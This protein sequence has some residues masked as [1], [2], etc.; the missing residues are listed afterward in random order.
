[1]DGQAVSPPA[2]VIGDSEGVT[3]VRIG[4]K[5]LAVA[6][7]LTVSGALVACGGG[8]GAAGGGAGSE[9][10]H[11]SGP[12]RQ[13]QLE[14]CAQKE[15]GMLLYTQLIVD[16]AVKPL[17]AGFNKQYPWAKVDYLRNSGTT[18]VQR[19][20]NEQQA[21]QVQADVYEGTLAGGAAKAAGVLQSF[22]T[23]VTDDYPQQ[24]LD[25]DHMWAPDVHYYGVFAYNTNE[26]PAA[27]VPKSYD[28]LLSPFWQNK[29]AFGSDPGN[30]GPAF[31]T[32]LR[33]AWGEDKANDFL[34]SFANQ[35]PI[36]AGKTADSILDTVVSGEHPASLPALAHQVGN[37]I[38]DGAPI[39]SAFLNPVID[40]VSTVGLV[41]GAPHPCTAMLFIDFLLGDG[42][43]QVLRE[44]GYIPVNPK[45][46]LPEE[47][48]AN[49]PPAEM[50]HFVRPE[51]MN[52]QLNSS[53]QVYADSFA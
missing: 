21:R 35:H 44:A 36:D 9:A 13:A 20:V 30:S 25:P 38:K 17:I 34:A 4:K 12:D 16:D 3:T 14:S 43:G 23:P 24:F 50:Q 28:D 27:E 49:V 31:I 22:I 15:G 1:M 10:A 11:M 51:K 47:V 41:N 7:A 40:Q 8:G 32:M 33:D 5:A 26:V 2:T 46:Q 18:L 42:G 39:K 29:V 53:V 52:E 19:L 6:G 37:D 48:K 45:V